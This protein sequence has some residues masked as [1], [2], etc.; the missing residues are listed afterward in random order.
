MTFPHSD[1]I[2][3]SG[4]CVGLYQSYHFVATKAQNNYF[5][6]FQITCKILILLQV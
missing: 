3:E 1:T 4:I 5:C 2:I 6:E